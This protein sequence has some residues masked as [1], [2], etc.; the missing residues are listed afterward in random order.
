M[1]CP[2]VIFRSRVHP[3]G[4]KLFYPKENKCHTR[5]HSNLEIWDSGHMFT[6]P[7]REMFL[8][9]NHGDI[10][11]YIFHTDATLH[12]ND[13]HTRTNS[14]ANNTVAHRPRYFH[15]CLVTC[16]YMA[17]PNTFTNFINL[18]HPARRRFSDVWYR[19]ACKQIKLLIE[20]TVPITA[21]WLYITRSAA[22]GKQNV[23][24]DGIWIRAF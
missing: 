15:Y 9:N 14:D 23:L 2:S 7:I 22:V 8:R 1:V 6:I 10:Y 11:I 5:M 19:V 18:T 17:L 20:V 13:G 16:L 21:P 24:C 3:S 4:R 12:K